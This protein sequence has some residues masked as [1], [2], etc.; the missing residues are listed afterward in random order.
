MSQDGPRGHDMGGQP[1]GRIVRDEHEL[2]SWELRA[3]A[4]GE[5]LWGKTALLK[6]DELRRLR[7]D[8]GADAYERM[9]YYERWMHSLAQGLIEHGIVSVEEL[10]QAMER[11]A[12]PQASEAKSPGADNAAT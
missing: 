3:D 5:V 2:D 10:G 4:L 1:A 7:E 11:A 6:V 8:I 9:T 12:H